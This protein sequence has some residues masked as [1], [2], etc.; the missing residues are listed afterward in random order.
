MFKNSR[1]S[2]ELW[3]GCFFIV[4]YLQGVQKKATL[5][6]KYKFVYC[7]DSKN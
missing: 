2:V 6:K 5:R 7:Y 1:V 4:A 3:Q